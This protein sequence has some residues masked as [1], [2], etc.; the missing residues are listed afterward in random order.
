MSKLLAVFGATGNQGS[1]VV[2]FVLNDPSLSKQYRIRAITRDVP[3]PKSQ[4]LPSSVEVVAADTSDP[5]SLVSALQNV[6]IV[7]LMSTPAFGPNALEGEF[8]T[9]KTTVDI[10]VAQGVDYIIFSTLPSVAEISKGKYT[11]VTPF[12]AKAKAEGYIRLLSPK[13]SSAFYCPGSFMENF[14]HPA[15]AGIRRLGGDAEEK[16]VME[17]HVSGN[18]RLPLIA[19]V[20]DT[21]K[22]VG[23]ILA[24]PGKLKGKTLR[25]MERWYSLEEIVAKLS[26]ITGKKVEYKQV[27][28]KEKVEE[29]GFWEGLFAEYF[30][31]LEE[32]GYFGLG[33][34]E[35][36]EWSQSMAW[37]KLVEFEEWLERN[38][39]VLS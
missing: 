36:L 17:R 10:A 31:Y 23:A 38:E 19:A 5:K 2:K 28:L 16:W 18:T 11:R 12:D 13:V 32:F 33:Q 21:G 1:S 25:A 6:H 7:C 37:G 4:A 22:F 3:S 26:K 9:I 8:Q 15:A 39:I 24:D 20:E 30:E 27:E 35:E 14:L 29:M 34:D